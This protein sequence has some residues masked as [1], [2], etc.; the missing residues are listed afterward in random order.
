MLGRMASVEGAEGL[1]GFSRVLKRVAGPVQ[2]WRIGVWHWRTGGFGTGG[3]YSGGLEDR[4]FWRG[5]RSG[6]GLANRVLAKVAGPVGVLQIEV[7]LHRRAG[8]G[9]AKKFCCRG[10]GS[11]KDV[12]CL[13]GVR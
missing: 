6:G 12:A 10:G 7:S 5:R 4:V 11:R 2:G 3:G 9:V 13:Q 8:G 1:A